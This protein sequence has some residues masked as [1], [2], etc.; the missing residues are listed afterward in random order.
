MRR[1]VAIAAMA[2]A[3]LAFA[4][5]AWSGVVYFVRTTG[6]D[7]NDGRTWAAAW[8]TS[9][10]VQNTVVA[11]DTVIWGR[12]LWAECRIYPPAGGSPT[13][14]T[15]YAC[16]T[17]YTG[18]TPAQKLAGRYL[19]V[20][21]GAKAVT[22]WVDTTIAGNVVQ[23]SVYNPSV[24]C[25][26]DNGQ[27]I[28][29]QCF[30]ARQQ[31]CD[32]MIIPIHASFALDLL[33]TAQ[34]GHFYNG[35][36][37]A[38]NVVY[39]K[40]Y[41]GA[42][43]ANDTV[44]VSCDAPLAFDFQ[45]AKYVKVWG[46]RIEMGHNGAV[47]F[48]GT[49]AQNVSVEHCLI[50]RSGVSNGNNPAAVYSEGQSQTAAQNNTL[51][52]DSI[53]GWGVMTPSS[54]GAAPNDGL[55][56][57]GACVNIYNQNHFV[58]ES[59]YVGGVAAHAIMFKQSKAPGPWV[60]STVRFSTIDG[61]QMSSSYQHGSTGVYFLFRCSDDSVYGNVIKNIAW[62]VSKEW[63]ADANGGNKLMIYNN[64]F[65]NMGSNCFGSKEWNSV[66]GP[67]NDG[68][69]DIRYNVAHVGN[70]D[71][72]F[73]AFYDNATQAVYDTTSSDFNIWYRTTGTN[74]GWCT[75]AITWSAWQTGGD[76][77][78]GNRAFDVNSLN[79][80]PGLANPAAGDFSRP[81]AS[82]EMY[83]LYGGRTWTVFGA[84]QTATAGFTF[85]PLP[86]RKRGGP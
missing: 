41:H 31:G 66:I 21:N 82:G 71:R 37:P 20:W 34:P 38:G 42:L 67:L 47:A 63:E 43:T 69:T 29:G 26:T 12:G 10:K 76:G 36:D 7:G 52:S 80:N 83:E 40:G 32:S 84:V 13:I 4:T 17:W 24:Y 86:L 6:N 70:M 57:H 11:G 55:F 60:G 46:M 33:G 64:T 28:Y 68:R 59:C 49:G 3:F 65:Y 78:C 79:T 23:K 50:L 15:I 85:P 61:L 44:W 8:Q 35:G 18:T 72:G 58:V 27:G 9:S 53:I 48:R 51:R 19:T 2:A 74:Y 75:A 56:Q 1:F 73:L 77:N 22:G 81:L 30:A 5:E 39:V 62:G 25:Q 54:L 14:Q 45:Q 16:S